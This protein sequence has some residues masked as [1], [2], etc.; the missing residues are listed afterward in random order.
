MSCRHCNKPTGTYTRGGVTKHYV[1]CF[2]CRGLP[3][4]GKVPCGVFDIVKNMPCPNFMR[5]SDKCCFTCKS[6]S[7]AIKC[8]S[9]GKTYWGK[10][11]TRH[12]K[13]CYFAAKEPLCTLADLLGPTKISGPASC[14]PSSS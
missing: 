8:E 14:L 1:S 4:P 10:A 12:C 7:A 2:D 9:C 11:W 5:E 13:K 6:R 3:P